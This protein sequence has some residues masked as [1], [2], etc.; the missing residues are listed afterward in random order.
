MSQ[1]LFQEARMN[2]GG[3][4]FWE[5][6]WC[7]DLGEPGSGEVERDVC[8]SDQACGKGQ[9]KGDKNK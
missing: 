3:G 5:A 1:I 6:C 8:K 7:A 2:G 4:V 9:M